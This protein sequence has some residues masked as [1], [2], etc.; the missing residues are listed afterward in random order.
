MS[1]FYGFM[2]S[3]SH[4]LKQQH[5]C[6]QVVWPRSLVCN[7]ED[8]AHCL[9]SPLCVSGAPLDCWWQTSLWTDLSSPS[10]AVSYFGVDLH[11]RSCLLEPLQILSHATALC[12]FFL[13]WHV[14][15]T[16]VSCW[17]SW[18]ENRERSGVRDALQPCCH[19]ASARALALLLMSRLLFRLQV[20]CF[21]HQEHVPQFCW[22]KQCP[23]N[24]VPYYLAILLSLC[25]AF[26]L[27]LTHIHLHSDFLHANL[28]IS[29]ETL[30]CKQTKLHF[31]WVNP[32]P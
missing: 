4:I 32:F 8:N 18:Q 17:F 1:W 21:W 31:S 14:C 10:G 6:V 26:L 7:T 22:W 20:I 2:L 24:S 29:Y 13:F 3:H 5:T 28:N 23:G 9:W 25:S 11:F 30:L 16:H 27:M 12:L 15:E 19:P